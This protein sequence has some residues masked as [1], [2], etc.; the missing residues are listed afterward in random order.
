MENCNNCSKCNGIKDE[1]SDCDNIRCFSC[2]GFRDCNECERRVCKS[3]PSIKKGKC[4]LCRDFKVRLSKSK[5]NI[6][7]FLC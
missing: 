2:E 6:A 3:C 1:C 4:S 7:L 5:N